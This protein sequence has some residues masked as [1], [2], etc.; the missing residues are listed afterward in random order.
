[1]IANYGL[2]LTWVFKNTTNNRLE[3]LHNTTKAKK[4]VNDQNNK[5]TKDKNNI[6]NL[7]SFYFY[8]LTFSSSRE[9]T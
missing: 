2:K 5:L 3:S 6:S 7:A 1:M 8:F 4:L 9:H